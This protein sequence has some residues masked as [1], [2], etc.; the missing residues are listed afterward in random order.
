MRLPPRHVLHR[1]FSTRLLRKTRRPNIYA[2]ASTQAQRWFKGVAFAAGRGRRWMEPCQGH[3]TTHLTTTMGPLMQGRGGTQVSGTPAR[4]NITKQERMR[5]QG[6]SAIHITGDRARGYLCWGTRRWAPGG[7]HQGT[8]AMHEESGSQLSHPTPCCTVPHP[9]RTRY[10]NVPQSRALSVRV[11]AASTLP[12]PCTLLG[13]A[14]F[15]PQITTQI[16]TLPHPRLPPQVTTPKPCPNTNNVLRCARFSGLRSHAPLAPHLARALQL[17]ICTPPLPLPLTPAPGPPHP[18]CSRRRPRPT[19]AGLSA[20][21]SRCS[22]AAPGSCRDTARQPTQ[23]SCRVA[24]RGQALGAVNRGRGAD[25]RSTALC[26]CR[27][28][29]EHVPVASRRGRDNV[30]A[31]LKASWLRHTR[32]WR[33]T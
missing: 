10:P 19:P 8:G 15:R 24:G 33:A 30:C 14:G 3:M 32:Q 22:P 12:T 17:R 26:S 21:W 5:V 18:H 31:P 28:G 16:S 1:P 23:R 27:D 11:L 9:S 4:R 29:G 6:Q 2:S 25:A 13:H 7:G 20:C